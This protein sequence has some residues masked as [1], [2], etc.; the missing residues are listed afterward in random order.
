MAEDMPI[1][2]ISEKA[3]DTSH[4][5][6]SYVQVRFSQKG[7]KSH[8]EFTSEDLKN[9]RFKTGT[10]LSVTTSKAPVFKLFALKFLVNLGS[11]FDPFEKT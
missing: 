10:F 2:F 5:T 1:F 8:P 4:G 3:V 9:K 7:S 6:N 11:D